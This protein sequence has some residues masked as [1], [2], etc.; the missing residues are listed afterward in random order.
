[1]AFSC[2]SPSCQLTY[3]SKTISFP[4]KK[5]TELGYVIKDCYPQT[6]GGQEA[7]WQAGEPK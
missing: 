5:E 7:Q 1:M 6:P 4:I 3:A 2:L